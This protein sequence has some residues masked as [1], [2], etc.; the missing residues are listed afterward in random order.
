MDF[1]DGVEHGSGHQTVPGKRS[2]GIQGRCDSPSYSVTH[3]TIIASRGL[4]GRSGKRSSEA[5][6]LHQRDQEF[7]LVGNVP[8]E[9][10]R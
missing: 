10:H 8:V 5:K 9:R 3:S 7:V 4:S 6:C 1:F 2:S